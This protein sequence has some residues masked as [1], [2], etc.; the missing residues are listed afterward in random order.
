MIREIPYTAQ[1]PIAPN[2]VLS[3]TVR[4]GGKGFLYPETGKINCVFHVSVD[5]ANFQKFKWP[6]TYFK[7]VLNLHDEKENLLEQLEFQ[8]KQGT[9][10]RAYSLSK[11]TLEKTKRIAASIIPVN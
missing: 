8:M 9:D 10:Q 2:S 5:P 11:E 7:I 1:S 3:T 4:L 6:D